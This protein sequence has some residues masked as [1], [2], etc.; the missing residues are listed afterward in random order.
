MRLIGIEM[1]QEG[2]F[3]QVSDIDGKPQDTI[4][5]T[6]ELI[7]RRGNARLTACG[8]DDRSEAWVE[9]LIGMQPGETIHLETE[10]DHYIYFYIYVHVP[11]VDE[12]GEAL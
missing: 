1:N 6:L 11:Y 12:T 4:P 7:E 5:E 10:T 9:S 2:R 8:W 3:H